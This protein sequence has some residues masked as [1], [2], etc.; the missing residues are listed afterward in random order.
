M[1][2]VYYDRTLAPSTK[3]TCSA[4]QQR[5]MSFCKLAKVQSIPA[6]VYSPSVCNSPGNL[7]HFLCYYQNLPLSYKTHAHYSR[8]AQFLQPTAYSMTPAGAERYPEETILNPPTKDMAAKHHS[9]YGKHSAVAVAEVK[10]LHDCHDM[11]SVLSYFFQIST[12][13]RVLYYLMRNSTKHAIYAKV[14]LQ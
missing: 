9:N 7:Q 8:D 14:I 3:S 12:H 1:T 2:Q 13:Q 11:D 5:F 10:V 4:G 6:S